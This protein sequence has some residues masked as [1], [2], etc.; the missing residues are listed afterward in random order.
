[1]NSI[2]VHDLCFSYPGNVEVFGNLNMSI[3]LGEKAGISGA[4]GSGKSTL[5]LLLMGLLK[6]ESGTIM[7]RDTIMKT[8]HDFK[9]ARVKTGFLFQDP[10]D[11]LFCPTVEEDIAF[12]LLNRGMERTEAGKKVDA[13]CEMLRISHLKKRV[14]FHLSWGQKRLVSLAGVLV[15]DPELLLLDEPTS[16]VDDQVTGIL[17]DFLDTYSGTMLLSSHDKEFVDHIC[18]SRY[19]LSKKGLDPFPFSHSRA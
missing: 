1:M 4:N 18:T 13:L 19:R 7:L 9:N 15:L 5:F 14:P 8:E 16:G 10:D 12:G 17:L 11:Q 3:G 6:P 2:T